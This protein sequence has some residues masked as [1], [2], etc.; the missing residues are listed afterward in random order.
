MNKLYTSKFT[1]IQH[2]QHVSFIHLEKEYIDLYR[3][4]RNKYILDFSK[5]MCT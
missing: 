4:A 5:Y 3:I 2:V 1:N